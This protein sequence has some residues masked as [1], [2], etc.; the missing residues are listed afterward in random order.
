MD[1]ER[2]GEITKVDDEA[3]VVYGWASVIRKGGRTQIDTQG[4]VIPDDVMEAAAWDF[5]KHAGVGCVM[6]A[7]DP[8]GSPIKVGSCVA[9]FPLTAVTKAAFGIES[10]IDGWMFGMH[11][12]DD[13]V[14]KMVKAGELK[15]FSIGGKG[16]GVIVDA[17]TIE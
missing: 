2:A 9:S 14:W 15:G 4:D 5:L 10:D 16:G 8:A 13:G 12:T 6:H 3:R 7:R 17:A 1:I 11:V